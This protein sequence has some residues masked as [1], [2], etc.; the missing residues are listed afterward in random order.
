MTSG[1]FDRFLL[2]IH[3]IYSDAMD[4]SA[5]EAFVAILHEETYGVI[6]GWKQCATCIFVLL[7]II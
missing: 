6:P 1:T 4:S 3:A 7:M 5:H 2:G